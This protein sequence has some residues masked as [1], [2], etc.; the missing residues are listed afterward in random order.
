MKV[1]LFGG[2]WSPSCA[3]YAL[4]RTF[5]DHGRDLHEAI[6]KANRNFYV[7]DLL[8]SVN[9]TS[10]TTIVVHH[11][12]DLLHKGGFRLTKWACNYSK[13]LQTIPLTERAAAVKEI[14][15]MDKL[16]T[17]RALGIL[18]DLEKDQ[19]AVQVHI[20]TRPETKRGLLSMIS[21]LYDPLSI[22]APCIIRAKMI[23]QEECRRGTGW[24][25]P[26]ANE[27]KEAWRRWLRGLPHLKDIRIPRCYQ[28]DI[29]STTTDIQLHHFSD[30][31]QRVYG[32]V[33]YLRLTDMMGLHRV[34]FVYGKAKLAP[35][36][37][38]TIP[39]LELCAAVLATKADERLRKEL[40]LS[41][42]QSVFWTDS[43]TLLRYIRNTERR[44]HTFVAN[45][46]AVIHEESDPDQWRYVSSGLNPADDASRGL[47][48]DELGGCSRWTQGPPFLLLD[49]NQWPVEGVTRE[50]VP[51]DDPEVKRKLEP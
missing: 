32:A 50:G 47:R 43:T 45:R 7:D 42:S 24:D 10:K 33:S 27:S 20:P 51:S 18:W 37:Q 36:K 15:L 29:E 26:Q 16:P 9:S 4:Q 41:V 14:P 31:S 12:R 39:R 35:L 8:L 2:V 49:K 46:I 44:F 1:H 38:L 23:F 5:Q 40:D 34:A 6:T 13:V 48:G 3:A 28:H 19:L 25:D 21:S 30:A 22:L 17:E 11:L